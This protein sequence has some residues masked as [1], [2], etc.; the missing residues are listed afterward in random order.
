MLYLFTDTQ[1]NEICGDEQL[2]YRQ[3]LGEYQI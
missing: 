2:L 1:E 3:L